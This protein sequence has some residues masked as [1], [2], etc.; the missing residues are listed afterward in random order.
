MVFNTVFKLYITIVFNHFILAISPAFLTIYFEN[1]DPNARLSFLS[2]DFKKNRKSDF[3]IHRFE[4]FAPI[5]ELSLKIKPE[6][7]SSSAF[8]LTMFQHILV[9]I[10]IFQ[11]CVYKWY[12]TGFHRLYNACIQLLYDV[13]VLGLQ[14]LKLYSCILYNCCIFGT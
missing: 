6:K 7:P 10:S 14:K 5:F 4:V 1:S 9:K 11:S 13:I 3:E 8:F 2:P 12:I